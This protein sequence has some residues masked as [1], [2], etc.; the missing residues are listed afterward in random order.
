MIAICSIFHIFVAPPSVCLSFAVGLVHLRSFPMRVD[1]LSCSR[2]AVNSNGEII[3]SSKSHISSSILLAT[4]LF[5]CTE[6]RWCNAPDPIGEVSWRKILNR[7]HFLQHSTSFQIPGL[8][9]STVVHTHYL[10][11]TNSSPVSSTPSFQYQFSPAIDILIKMYELFFRKT[12]PTMNIGI[13]KHCKE[14]TTILTIL[15]HNALLCSNYVG[16]PSISLQTI[17]LPFLEFH[18]TASTV[19]Q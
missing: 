3:L 11:T 5:L 18:D 10:Y 4:P 13:R 1:D 19:A 2:I 8:L 17:I 14:V 7:Y 16:K 12:L 15:L 9:H 6:P